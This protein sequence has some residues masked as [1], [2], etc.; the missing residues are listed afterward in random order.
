MLWPDLAELAK[1][2][3]ARALQEAR[4]N[5]TAAARCQ[6]LAGVARFASGKIAAAAFAESEAAAETGEDA[7]QRASWLAYPICAAVERGETALAA[8]LIRKALAE[9]PRIEPLPSRAQALYELWPAA[10][11]GGPGLREPVW[12]AALAHCPPDKWRVTRLY[13][14]I[15]GTLRG[16][17]EHEADRA[18]AA[19]PQGETRATFEK[20]KARG[21]CRRVRSFF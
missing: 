12:R 18:I 17:S 10:F 8:Q 2:D 16:E 21:E 19:L 14:E 9:I 7:F 1:T 3:P 5:P 15:A 11:P 13:R 6:D 20:A 4:A